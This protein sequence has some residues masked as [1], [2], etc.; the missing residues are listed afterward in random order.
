MLLHNK[1]DKETLRKKLMAEPFFRKTLSFYRYTH[2]TKPHAWRDA[3]F[4]AFSEFNI[5]GRIYV[6]HEGINAQLSVPED[7]WEQCLAFLEH[8]PKLKDVPL[9]IAIEDDGKSFYKLIVRVKKM[10]VADGLAPES[11]DVSNVG[12]HLTA[13]EWNAAMKQKDTV[14]V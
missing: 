11:Y 14:V 1:E 13:A 8:D 6:A 12:T 7:N 3:L 10:I 5:L 4:L 9:K 2:I